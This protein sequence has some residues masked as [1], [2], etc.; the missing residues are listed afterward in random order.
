MREAIRQKLATIPEV[1]DRVFEPHAAGAATVKPYIVISQ[2]PDNEESTWAGFR[3]IVEVWPNV[4]R[5]TFI[6]V[7]SLAQKAIDALVKD[8]LT[9][10]AGEVFTCIYQG[11][12]GDDVVDEEWDIITRGLR[13]AILALQPVVVPETVADDP[14]VE[15]VSAW[16]ETLLGVGWTV[17]RNKWPL[18]YVKPAVMWRVAKVDVQG[19]NRAAFKVKKALVAHV[20][21]STPN[22]QVTGVASITEGLVTTIK[23]PLNLAD[24]RYMTV[25]DVKGDYQADA[26]TAGQVKAEL[27]RMTMR[28]FD[29]VALTQEVTFELKEKAGE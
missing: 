21:G 9:T 12:A 29:E 23:V 24:R 1:G 7:D 5:T 17:H 14:W 19:A 8:P 15:A 3:R 16:T 27:S 22:Q 20:L 26:L 2:G 18:G 10:S 28:P 11:V 6:S 4:S 25:D 13:F